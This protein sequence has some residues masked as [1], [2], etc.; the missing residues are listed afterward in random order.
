[1]F[2]IKTKNGF[3]KSFYKKKVALDLTVANRIQLTTIDKRM[4]G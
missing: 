3:M 1:M 4:R 2:F